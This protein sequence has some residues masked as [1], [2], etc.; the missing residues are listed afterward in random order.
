MLCEECQKIKAYV[1]E[2]NEEIDTLLKIN[3]KSY[4]IDYLNKQAIMNTDY[5]RECKICN[6]KS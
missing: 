1:D 6:K 2:I 3:K 5:L 4:R